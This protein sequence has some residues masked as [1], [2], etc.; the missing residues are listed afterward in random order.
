[1]KI[2]INVRSIRYLASP[3]IT[4]DICLN[5]FCPLLSKPGSLVEESNLD[6]ISGQVSESL[7]IVYA[8]SCLLS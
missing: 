5:K 2:T 3:Y 7:I 4:M 1:M 6:F 8:P